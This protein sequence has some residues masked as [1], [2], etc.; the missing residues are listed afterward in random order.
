L[1]SRRA[2]AG[3]LLILGLLPGSAGAE[4]RTALS[5]SGLYGLG[6]SSFRE[7]RTFT[8]FAE[9]GR[10]DAGYQADPGPGFEGAVR[11]ML[12]RRFGL[13]VALGYLK[14]NESVAF[15]AALPHPLYFG[16]PRP[17]SGSRSGMSYTETAGHLDLVFVP[18]S[19]RHLEASLFAGVSLIKVRADLIDHIEYTQTYPYDTVTAVSA[20]SATIQD[21]PFGF[22]VGASL[23]GRLSQHIALGA[24]GRFSRAKARLHPS[25][26]NT[27]GFDAGG[28]QIGAG[29]RFLF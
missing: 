18:A 16:R 24:Q 14:R 28:F 19:G 20:P 15:S 29:I 26:G 1:P 23:D 5:L 27:L 12:G 21:N 10:F 6:S 7:S 4:T 13:A 9:A 8:Q 3:G 25:P 22:N 2:A 17:A 11:Q